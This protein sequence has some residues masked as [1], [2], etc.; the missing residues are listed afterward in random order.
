M[1]NTYN[2]P[3]KTDSSKLKR[4]KRKRNRVRALNKVV[5]LMLLLLPLLLGA[6]LNNRENAASSAAALGTQP[7]NNQISL[8]KGALDCA[9]QSSVSHGKQLFNDSNVTIKKRVRPICV[10]YSCYLLQLRYCQL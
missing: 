9:F 2:S 6:N 8:R 7:I 3:F 1:R 5:T 4:T 10:L